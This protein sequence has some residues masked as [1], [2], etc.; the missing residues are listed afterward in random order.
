[1]KRKQYEERRATLLNE[2]RACLDK[3]DMEGFRVKKAEVEALD[4]EFE[5]MAQAQADLTALSSA[6]PPAPAAVQPASSQGTDTVFAVQ[7]LSGAPARTG[8]VF[9][10]DGYKDAFMNYVCR[11]IPIPAEFRNGPGLHLTN[12]A[13][14][15]TTG[16]VPVVIPTTTSRQIIRELKSH[17]AVYSSVRKLNVQ[18]GI[19]FPILDLMPE[20]HWIDESTP[21][22]DQ[23]LEAKKKV[24]FSYYGLE[25]KIAQSLLAS[26]V[27]FS[28]FQELFVPLAVEA[29]IRKIETGIF[30]ADGSGKMLGVTQDARVT[31]VI[32]LAAADMTKWDGWKKKV[33]AKIP[34]SYGTGR[35]YM[36]KG[37][38]DGYIDG[39]VDSAG[40]PVGRTNYGIAENGAQRF[41]GKTVELVEDDV[42]KPYDT[43]SAGDVI[44]V[45]M[46]PGN[47]A[48]NSNMEMT[49]VRW[50]DNDTNKVK[51]KVMM[52]LDGKAL[53]T[54]G[55]ILIKKGA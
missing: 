34:I 25:C 42:L 54:N 35:F 49:V 23:K 5:T 14:T 30:T 31:N 51:T 43:A 33:F 21:S 16:D 52:V 27:T 6:Q 40:Q 3:G 39:M 29:I 50:T 17:G 7:D 8:D 53:D 22:D 47:Y 48:I 4:N 1:M 46:D 45:F 19:D 32:T 55:I 2:A 12:A 36:A 37:T 9:D 13:R 28:E 15:T 38:W 44:A 24:S 26:A 18:G 10:S 20:A 41:G 11:G